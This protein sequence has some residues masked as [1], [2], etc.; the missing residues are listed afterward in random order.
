MILA[1]RSTIMSPRARSSSFAILML[2]ILV[3]S[4]VVAPDASAQQS[5]TGGRFATRAELEATAQTLERAAASPAYS[6]RLRGQAQRD[7]AQVRRRL[8]SG[9]FLIGERIH[10]TV[11]ATETNF[12]DTLTVRDSLV[13]EIPGIRRFSLAGVLR[14]ELQERAHRE[15]NA[16]VRNA[17]VTARPLMRIAVLGAVTAPGFFAVTPETLV[18]QLLMLAGSPDANAPFER[19]RFMRADTVL[20]EGKDVL[21]AIADGRTLGS[22]DLRDGDVLRVPS[23]A[24][25][26]DRASTLQIVTVFAAP[27]IALLLTR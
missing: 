11:S 21:R 12:D 26:W 19:L 27:L 13:V 24:A 20:M 16:V 14:A 15:V 23:G 2:G 7:L 4:L 10:V 17:S 1:Y 8:I 22:L 18:D 25:P 5:T 3:L 6:A 9:D